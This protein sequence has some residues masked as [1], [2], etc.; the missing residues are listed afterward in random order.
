MSQAHGEGHHGLGACTRHALGRWSTECREKTFGETPGEKSLHF[1]TPSC[2]I[3]ST[4][5]TVVLLYAV[6]LLSSPADEHLPTGVSPKYATVMALSLSSALAYQR[7][8]PAKTRAK[9]PT[10]VRV[11]IVIRLL[12]DRSTPLRHTWGSHRKDNN[13]FPCFSMF[14]FR[15]RRA[16]SPYDTAAPPFGSR[17]GVARTA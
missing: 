8:G 9:S 5:S 14:S 16:A 13:V 17:R 10:I 1:R 7:V 11:R 3:Y 4:S 15:R 12:A 6:C 2:S